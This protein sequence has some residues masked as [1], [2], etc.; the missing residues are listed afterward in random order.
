MD[1]E[2][3]FSLFPEIAAK[4]TRA[5]IISGAGSGSIPPGEYL[6]VESYCA[7]LNCD[8]RRTFLNIVAKGSNQ[9]LAVISYGWESRKFYVRW[10]GVDDPE[11]I[12]DLKGPALA[13]GQLQ[14]KLAPHFLELVTRL[15][16]S[17]SAYV[18]RLK[19][20]YQMFKSSLIRAPSRGQ[21]P[22][23]KRIKTW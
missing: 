17:D 7:T 6:L 23:P 3:F 14:S 18:T 2:P 9:V 16:L 22:S 4:E 15:V 21:L 10:F 5:I 19:K 1:Y 11:A 13:A 12:A 20:H 8:C